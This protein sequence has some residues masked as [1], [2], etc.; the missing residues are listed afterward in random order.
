M[1]TREV[2]DGSRER[3]FCPLSEPFATPRRA[4][5][6]VST[7]EEVGG[8]EELGGYGVGV[9]EV[10]G[11]GP[12]LPAEIVDLAGDRLGPRG[13]E[14]PVLHEPGTIVLDRRQRVQV[15]E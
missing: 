5:C 9:D 3:R 8:A 14:S 1:A 12:D 2:K 15:A 6:D 10:D 4:I 7:L 11:E 13:G